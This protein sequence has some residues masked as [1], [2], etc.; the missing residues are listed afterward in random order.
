MYAVDLTGA[1]LSNIYIVHFQVK[2]PLPVRPNNVCLPTPRE[3]YTSSLQY[4]QARLVIVP[5]LGLVEYDRRLKFDT[6]AIGFR[7][8][9]E[10]V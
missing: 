5:A 3:A 9:R 1:H 4:T 6:L 2:R 8:L 7:G 10:L